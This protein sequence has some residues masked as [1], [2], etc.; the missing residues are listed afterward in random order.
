MDATQEKVAAII[1]SKQ[2]IVMLSDGIQARKNSN[3]KELVL[4]EVEKNGTPV[5]FVNAPLEM[6][7]FGG[8][9]SISLIKSLDSVFETGNSLLLDYQTK[10]SSATSKDANVNLGIYSGA[11]TMMKENRPWLITI[12]CANQR[13]KLALKNVVKEISKFT[14]CNKFYTNFTPPLIKSH[15]IQL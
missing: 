4:L 15:L 8:T 3:E 11:L 2:F 7:E 5:Y 9:D 12:C 6:A 10:L 1:A 14:E 13:F